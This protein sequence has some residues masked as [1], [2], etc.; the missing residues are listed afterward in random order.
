MTDAERDAGRARAMLA[1]KNLMHWNRTLGGECQVCGASE[2]E[3]FYDGR[4]YEAWWL[5]VN[6]YL[7]S[8]DGNGV[9]WHTSDVRCSQV[10]GLPDPPPD[11]RIP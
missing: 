4:P 1:G 5:N 10:Y 7:E 6:R 11:P 2:R 8:G 3:Y 9:L